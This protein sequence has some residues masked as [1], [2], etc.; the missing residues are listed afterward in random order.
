M[1]NAIEPENVMHTFVYKNGFGGRGVV[2]HLELGTIV[3]EAKQ[4]VRSL[5]GTVS[6][7]VVGC[8]AC[9]YGEHKAVAEVYDRLKRKENEHG[10]I[11]EPKRV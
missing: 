10:T 1:S 11:T 2:W 6:R 3:D 8:D 5:S 4:G 9:Q 7:L